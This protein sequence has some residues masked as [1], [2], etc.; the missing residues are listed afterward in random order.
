MA[1]GGV[2]LCLLLAGGGV[3]VYRIY[4]TQQSEKALILNC[5]TCDTRKANQIRSRESLLEQDAEDTSD[6]Q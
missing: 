2:I 6:D 5:S 1:I 4:E 3:L